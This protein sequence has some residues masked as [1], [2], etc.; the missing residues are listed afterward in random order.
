VALDLPESQGPKRYGRFDREPSFFEDVPEASLDLEE[1][2]RVVAIVPTEAEF[3]PFLHPVDILVTGAEGVIV[4]V[5][6]ADIGR[7]P[8]ED[9]PPAIDLE[10]AS[11]FLEVGKG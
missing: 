8:T 1:E 5:D 3:S 7:Y 11:E 10:N 2:P 9:H 4:E 6:A